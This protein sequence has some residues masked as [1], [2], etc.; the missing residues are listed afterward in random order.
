MGDVETRLQWME[1][2]LEISRELIS[3]VSLDLLLR[4]LVEA[5]AELAGSEMASILL[6]NNRTGEL[7]FM[8]S[9]ILADQSTDVPVPIEGSIAGVAFSSGKP[10]I[11]PDVRTDPRYYPVVEELTGL[12]VCSLLAVPLQ[13]KERPIGVLEVE[14]K[15]DGEEFGQKD[16]EMLT[17]LAA[18]AT[19]SIEN[20][21]LVETLRGAHNLAEALRQASAALSS[22]LNY[23]EVLD[24]ILEQISQVIPQAA[25]NIMLIED[26]REEETVRVLRGYGYEQ[27]GTK[28]IPTSTTFSVADVAGLRKMRQTAQPL[29]IP[30]VER[31]KDWVYSRPEHTW[32]KSYAGV[33]IRIRDRVVGFLNV[34]SAVPGFF[35]QAAAE[36]LQAFAN[37]AAIAIENARL[38]DQA[39]RELGERV[40]AEEELRKHRDHLEELVKER[41]VKLVEAIEQLEQEIAERARVEEAVQR[42]NQEL[43]A[44]NA[45]AQ[46]LST[47]LELQDIL[48]QAL[49]RTVNALGFAGGLISLGDARTGALTLFSHTGLPESFI[50]HLQTQG[51][52]D[53]L[54]NFVY[55]EKRYLGLEYLHKDLPADVPAIKLLEAGMQS[56]AGTPIIYQERAL[57]TLCLFDTVPHPVSETDY[58]LLTA[59]GRQIGVAVENARLFRDAVRERQVSHTLLDTA[60][61]LSATLRLDKLLERALDE[62]QRVVP[63]DTASISML[64]GERCW[65]VASRGLERTTLKG[66]VLTER[67]LVH[68]AV[69][70]RG[71]VIVPDVHDEPDWSPIEEFGPVRSWLG[72]PLTVK[73]QVIGVLMMSSCHPFTYDEES[74][75]PALAFAHQVAL[76]IENSRLYEQ[77]QAQLHDAILL[78]SVTTALSATLDMDKM[79]P[80]VARSLCEILNGDSAEIYSLDEETNTVAVIADY[81][82]SATTGSAQDHRPYLGQTYALADFPA[83]AE[84]LARRRPMQIQ[85]ND[86]ETSPRDRTRLNAHGSQATLFL[87]MVTGARVLG[88]A[89]VWENQSPRH[90]TQGEIATGQ[91]LIHQATIGLENAW[92]YEELKKAKEAAEVATEA[93]SSFLAMMSHEIRTPMNG[94]IGMVELLLDTEL[95]EEQRDYAETIRVSGDSLLVI[96]NDILDF[97]KIEA[98]KM[99]LEE[100][101]FELQKCMA[102]VTDLLASKAAEK[103]IALFHSVGDRVPPYIVG[104][105]TRLRQILVNLVNNALKFTKRGHV[106]VTV[107]T[108]SQKN[109]LFEIQFAVQDTGIGI[110]R[111]R[112]HR[113]FQSFSQVDSSMTRKYGG[114]GLGLAISKRLS[115]LMGGRIWVESEE[116][117]GSTFFFTIQAPKASEL[118]TTEARLKKSK[119]DRELAEHLP[120][121]ILLVEDNAVNR[122]LAV[123]ILRKMGYSADVASNGLDALDMLK[124][125]DYDII[126]MD[127]QMPEMDGLEATRYIVQNWPVDERPKII[128]MTASVLQKDRIKCLQAGMDDYISKPIEVEAVQSALEHWGALRLNRQPSQEDQ[129]ETDG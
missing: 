12:E 21:R 98:G 38:Y 79:L 17:A 28:A 91:T 115:E 125:R 67:P 86:P 3:T 103:E 73:D 109:D 19:V 34:N 123:Y 52:D 62:L 126:F 54:C 57:G 92:L 23:D 72:V 31:D 80:Y 27:F 127:V 50:E 26:T 113:L 7:R 35:D 49:S 43:A 84:A 96:I 32:I 81:A 64:R 93:K 119:L 18:Q 14:N 6:L 97:S 48:D 1:R 68:R 87:P 71:P 94:V 112:L 85:V 42:R 82:A 4:K 116:G 8:A 89:Q 46:A 83:A 13:L 65:A 129:A 106:S 61:A 101:P 69:R 24:R 45:V 122:K 40:R 128:A 95:T 60:K 77:R 114:T 88:L 37:H 75:R 9:S 5:A 39:Q 120:L 55:R 76:A 10:L 47:S 30:Y 58:A 22:T 99:E 15:R 108:V 2:I 100:H 25:A 105:S 110:P 59:I 41:T 70:E 51:M 121:Q 16:V 56:Y 29:V 44:L 74:A 66:F 104:D 20:A 53:T 11:V 63:Y 111:D 117:K 78:Q 33:P 124:M 90:F 118:S 102:E 107:T 36:H